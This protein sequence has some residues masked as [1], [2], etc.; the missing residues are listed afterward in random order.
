MKPGQVVRIEFLDHCMN[1]GL[2]G[3][4][5]VLCEVFGRI[6]KVSK[7]HVVVV[8]WGVMDPT[9]ASGCEVFTVLRS[10]I[11]KVKVLR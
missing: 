7:D 3:T 8:S 4:D 11:L 5:P 1:E 9:R 2:E 6:F 10:T